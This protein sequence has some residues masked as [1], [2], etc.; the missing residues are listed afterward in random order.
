MS[1]QINLYNPAFLRQKKY[2]SARTMVQ[3]LALIACGIAAF[4]GYAAFQVKALA[5]IT[6]DSDRQLAVQRAQLA[7]LTKELGGQG[8]GTLLDELARAEAQ[9]KSRREL[10]ASLQTGVLGNVQGF[11]RYLAAF[12]RQQSQG[13]WL[14]GIS[15]GGDENDLLVRGRVLRAE[16]LPPY[17]RALSHEE[18]MRGRRVTELRLSASQD[19]AAAVAPGQPGAASP[20]SAAPRRPTRFVEFSLLAPRTLADTAKP[21]AGEPRRRAPS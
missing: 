14:T 7:A 12:A 18:V 1:Q 2:F 11:S 19:P 5:Q 17:L 10:L 8:K 9:V 6:A 3:A 21:E 4:T 13:V 15:L 20:A 16:L